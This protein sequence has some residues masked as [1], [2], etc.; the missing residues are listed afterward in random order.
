MLLDEF[1]EL[2]VIGFTMAEA[3]MLV[4]AA[5][6]ITGAD[7]TNNK[8]PEKIKIVTFF[9]F[10]SSPHLTMLPNSFTEAFPF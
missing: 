1:T 6:V 9:I 5:L 2:T 8:R 4:V 3:V 7:V 10:V